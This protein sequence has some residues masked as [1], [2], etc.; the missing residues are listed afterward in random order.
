[1]PIMEIILGLSWFISMIFAF[2]IGYVTHVRQT[3][4]MIEQYM[5]EEMHLLSSRIYEIGRKDEST[6]SS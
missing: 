3:H 2:G 1:M 6:I 4:K 5:C